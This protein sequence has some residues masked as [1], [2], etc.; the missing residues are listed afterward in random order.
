MSRNQNIK[1]KKMSNF[2][3]N[4]AQS[5]KAYTSLFLI[6]FLSMVFTNSAKADDDLRL[7]GA[8]QAIGG[9]SL[10]VNDVTFF[11]DANTELKGAHGATPDFSDFLVGDIVEVRANL[12][13]DSSYLATRVELQ[14]QSEGDDFEVEGHIES[15]G[16]D[17]LVVNSI[18]FF[19]DASTE[20]RGRHG[21]TPAFSDLQAGNRVEVRA[22]QQADGSFLASRIKLEDGDDDGEVEIKGVIEALGPDSLMVNTIVFAVDSSTNVFDHNNNL[23]SFTDLQVGGFVEVKANRRAD[24]SLLAMRIK[25]EDDHNGGDEI[26][27]TATIDTIFNDT[28]VVGGIAFITDANTVILDNNRLPI[29]FADLQIGMLVEI[30]G[31]RQADGSVL[32]TNIK[33]EDFFNDE[34]EVKSVID[35]LGVDWLAVAGH[36]FFVDDSTVVLDNANQPITFADLMVGQIV[37]VRADL[38]PDGTLLATR[39]HLEDG[40]NE[41]EMLGVIDS[42]DTNSLHVA[43]VK[44]LTDANTLVLDH[45]GNTINF[46]DLTV[47]LLV[48]IKAF[49]QPDSSLLAVRIKIEDSPGFSKISGTIGTVSSNQVIVSQ[50][51]FQITANTVILDEKFR[52]VSIADLA[53]NQAVTLWADAAAGQPLALQIKINA[54]GSVTGIDPL[55][56]A[57]PEVFELRQNYPNPFNPSTTIPFTINGANFHRVE[58]TI[59]NI[60]GQ[61]VRSLFSG[62]LDGGSYQFN[63]DGRSDQGL[64][65]P[66]GVYFYQLKAD[67]KVAAVKR[68]MLIK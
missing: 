44:F 20:I 53:A 1:E 4:L 42:L 39:I 5:F 28:V 22:S 54:T 10:V 3:T 40:A 8:I 11:V 2:K 51:D 23:I 60:L 48:Q 66:S 14:N 37:E 7:T 24:G 46:S 17:S 65:V 25:Q 33:V 47:G 19:V 63:W 9:D 6:L 26:E 67:R 41:L 68:M 34:V 43:G 56:P 58:L 50:F 27:F 21:S 18:T 52:P 36:I 12:Q 13:A 31:L 61:K 45:A 30:R 64:S 49:R 38:R 32:A 29:T 16:G 57:L 59:F 15:I 62:L 55:S 35:S